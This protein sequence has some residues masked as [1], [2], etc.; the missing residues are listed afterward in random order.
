MCSPIPVAVGLLAASGVTSA[1]SSIAAGRSAKKI[2]EY[3]AR[4]ARQ[5]AADATLRGKAAEGTHRRRVS[6]LIGR[7][8]AAIGASGAAVDQGSAFDIIEDTVALGELDALQIRNN[9]A[10]EALGYET[11]ATS[12]LFQGRLARR[13]ANVQAF[14]TLLGTGAQTTGL[15][16]QRR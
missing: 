5:Q 1:V 16:A 2:S 7:Q 4:I 9:A 13:E 12:L 15:L 3:N 6:Q 14:S 10:R 11:Q 8:R